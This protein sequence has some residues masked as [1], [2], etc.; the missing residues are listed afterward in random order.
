MRYCCLSMIIILEPLSPGL[1]MMLGLLVSCDKALHSASD[2]LSGTSGGG[3]Y[4]RRARM[5]CFIK[6]VVVVSTVAVRGSQLEL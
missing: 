5:F 4:V 6:S 2:R 1:I 3:R